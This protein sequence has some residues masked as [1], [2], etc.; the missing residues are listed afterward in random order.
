MVKLDRCLPKDYCHPFTRCLCE[1]GEIAPKRGTTGPGPH[2][3]FIVEPELPAHLPVPAPHKPHHRIQPSSGLWS[4]SLCGK[5]RISLQ[6]GLGIPGASVHLGHTGPPSHMSLR[7]LSLE[8]ASLLVCFL[9]SLAAPSARPHHLGLKL[10][11]GSVTAHPLHHVLL[12]GPTQCR[13]PEDREFSF[14]LSLIT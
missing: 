2:G 8:Q 10:R 13:F 5:G 4:Q 14:Y 7:W 12:S 11:Y 9:P 1:N 3:Q 6:T